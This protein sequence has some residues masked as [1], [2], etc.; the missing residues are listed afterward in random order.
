MGYLYLGIAIVFEVVATTALKA[1]ESF[2]QLWPSV[3]VC[4]GYAVT[5]YA[6]SLALQSITVGVAYAL[7][8]G[9]GIVLITTAG[10]FVY[11]QKV[12]LAGL[13]GMGLIIAGVVVIQLFSKSGAA[14]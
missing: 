9:L 13:L 3:I 1:S 14:A 8:S 2:T 7:W 6:L 10:F 5:F 4:V 11:G 12:D